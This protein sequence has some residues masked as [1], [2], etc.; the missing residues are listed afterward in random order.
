MA[1]LDLQSV[2]DDDLE[3]AIYGGGAGGNPATPGEPA[4]PAQQ[5]PP[6]TPEPEPEPEPDAPASDPY[7]NWKPDEKLA[8]EIRGRNPD[9]SLDESIARARTQL[10]ITEN[11]DP[12][13]EPTPEPTVQEQLAEVE[14]RLEEAGAQE[15]LFNNEIRELL[16]QQSKLSAKVER[17]NERQA[18]AEAARLQSLAD[19][20]T[21]S[22]ERVIALCPEATDPESLIGKAISAVITELRHNPLLQRP[23]S[24]EQVFALANLRLPEA[25]RVDMRRAP[26][27]PNLSSLSS[28]AASPAEQ[29]PPNA[30]KA[31]GTSPKVF[32]AS[33][34]PGSARTVQPATAIHNTGNLHTTLRNMD[35]D[36][37]EAAIY[38]D[39]PGFHIRG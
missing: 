15:G 25:Q 16:T 33:P 8:M 38:G 9:L 37:L 36:T 30:S 24:P 34:V 19:A 26:V 12:S 2:S 28:S 39:R 21:Q 14:R 20:R 7:A 10:G 23:D 11:G 18:E 5:D 31:P 35:V 1:T 29:G 27:D 4:D 3:A 6:P 22:R 32:T 17:D 13:P